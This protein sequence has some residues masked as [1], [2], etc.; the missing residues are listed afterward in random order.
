MFQRI[1]LIPSAGVHCREL[2]KLCGKCANVRMMCKHVNVCK[3]LCL[4]Y[5]AVVNK[6]GTISA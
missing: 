1:Q 3:A 5:A 4:C 6:H 2:L